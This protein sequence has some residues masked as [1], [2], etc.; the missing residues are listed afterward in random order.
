MLGAESGDPCSTRSISVGRKAMTIPKETTA[1]GITDPV[2]ITTLGLQAEWHRYP[3]RRDPQDG[4]GAAALP[5]HLRPR[6]RHIRKPLP[7]LSGSL[8]N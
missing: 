3:E 1:T 6:R 4:I 8:V 2:R 7:G 5:S